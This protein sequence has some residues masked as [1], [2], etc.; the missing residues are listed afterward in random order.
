MC[1]CI[2]M[3]KGPRRWCRWISPARACTGAATAAKAAARRSRRTWRRRCCC[4]RDGRTLPRRAGRWSTR[5]AVRARFSTEGALIAADA[6]PALRSRVFRVPGVARSRCRAVGALARA[7]RCARRG[8]RAARRCILGSD[9]DAEAVRMAIANGAHAGVADWVHVEKRALGDVAAAEGRKRAG[10]RESALRGAHRR[11]VGPAG[12]VRRARLRAARAIPGL[13]GGDSHRQSAAG[14]QFGHLRQAH[15]PGI[16]RHHRVPA[17]ALR[18]ERSERAASCRGSAR[19]L[20]EPA[21]RADVRQSAAQE[22]AALGSVGRAASTS[23]AFACTTPTCRNTPSPSICTDANPRHVYVQEYAP[24]KTVNQESARE[25]RREVL[26]VLPEVLERAAGAGAFA[27]AQTAEGRRAI[28]EARQ[29][30]RAPR[31]ARGRPEVLGQ[32]SRLPG[33]RAVSRPPHR[34]R[35]CCAPGPRTR[36]S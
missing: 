12:A 3:S 31:G 14:P 21:R 8:A 25:R 9:I 19:R 33:Y 26:A 36:I 23:I 18:S 5:C 32:F 13:A 17:A 6:A 1:C 7:R 22:S 10:R 15:A 27:R 16:Q 24:P 4:A 30:G 34:A 11:G 28:R 2:C 20:V 29:R 35:Q